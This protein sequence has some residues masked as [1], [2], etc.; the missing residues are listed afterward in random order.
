MNSSSFRRPLPLVLL[1]FALA[2]PAGATTVGLDVDVVDGRDTHVPNP[3]PRIDLRAL[4]TAKSFDHFIVRYRAGSPGDTDRG[5]RDASLN[6]AAVRAQDQL[7]RE[8]L[9]RGM[10]LPAPAWTLRSLRRLAV[11]GDVFA[12]SQK[13]DAQQVRLLLTQIGADPDVQYVEIDQIL[14]P[15]LIPNDPSYVNEW[16]LS[17]ADAGIRAN[18]AWD[19]STGTGVYV[20]VIDTGYTNHSDLLANVVPGYDFI[21]DVAMA[22]DGDGRDVNAHDPGDWGVSNSS[23][24]GTHVAGTIAA[25]TKNAKGVAGVAFGAKILP[26]RVLGVGCGSGADIA[27]AI[28]WAAGGSVA[29]VPANTHPAKVLNLSLGGGGGCAATYQN[30]IN[31]AVALGATVVVAAGN[32][33]L[34]TAGG[35]LSTCANVVVV[36][37]HTSASARSGFSNYGAM[38]DVSAPGS[39]ILSTINLGTTVP[40]AEGY[41]Y[42][43][44]TSM[45][46]PHVA[47]TVALA[48]SY[49]VARGFAM[50]TPAQMEAVLKSTS[51][52]MVQGCVG[53]TGSGVIDARSLLDIADGA[54]RL[55]GNGTPVTSQAAASGVVGLRYAMHTRATA[56]GLIFSSSGGTGD[57]DLYVKYGTMPTTLSY[58]CK[59]TTVGNNESCNI[60]VAQ[61]GTYYMLLRPASTF[62]GVT[63]VGNTSGN[64]KP[65]T[66]FNVANNGLTV[67]FTDASSDV[68][69]GVTSRS[70]NFGDGATSTATSPSHAFPS[71]GAYTVQET[72]SDAAGASNCMIKQVNV[73]PNPV[74]LSNGVPVNNLSGNGGAQL[75]FTLAVP[76]GA[77]NLHFNTTGGTG[78]ADLYVKF[79]SAPTL[80]SYDCVSAGAT[81]VETCTMPSATAGTWYV[82]VYA[83]STISGVSVSGTYTPSGSLQSAPSA[84]FSYASRGSTASFT[85]TSVEGNGGIASRRWDFGDGTSSTLA[86]PSHTFASPGNHTVTLTVSGVGGLSNVTTRQV[87]TD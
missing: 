11:G 9:A 56:Q 1:S 66:A 12:S 80:S 77:T 19:K 31:S 30:A 33:N 59:S 71:A 16:G 65:T 75:P 68:D 13:L 4:H 72:A 34:D 47:G 45:A 87:I 15:A 26:V 17:D 36:G 62:S 54:V 84:S 86:N 63:V 10:H 53:S 82:M 32:D 24:H 3:A 2:L 52:W 22:N 55:I 28:V 58:D 38:V 76:S 69:G 39:S 44:G 49:R 83:Y 57:A 74:A 43:Q 37:A 60:P 67:N 23:W 85:D 73:T 79:G 40:A 78:D 61:A 35:S 8:R 14:K 50:Y 41:A 81:T 46:T 5:A 6:R 21:S 20:A 51:Y 25:V 29:G 64:K 7:Q 70:W 18:T 42:Y 48:Q 27:D